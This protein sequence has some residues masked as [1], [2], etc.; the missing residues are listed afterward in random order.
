[1][2]VPPIRDPIAPIDF[3]QITNHTLPPSPALV[4][5]LQ[6]LW[7]ADFHG[8]VFETPLVGQRSAAP[9]FQRQATSVHAWVSPD[10]GTSGSS[11]SC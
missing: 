5:R 7:G 3:S 6:P 1:M 8:P 2:S 11:E 10:A 9:A 4:A